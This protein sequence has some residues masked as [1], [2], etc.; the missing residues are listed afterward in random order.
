MPHHEGHDHDHEHEEGH[1]GSFA[2]GQAAVEQHPEDEALGDFARGQERSVPTHE[3]R[4]FAEGQA[5]TAG[6]EP[7]TGHGEHGD[8]ARGQD[9]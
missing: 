3:E 4:D 8:F 6:G 5:A 1:E 7:S 2:E 9:D